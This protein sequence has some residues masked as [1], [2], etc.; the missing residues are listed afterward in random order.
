MPAAPAQGWEIEGRARRIPVGA[1]LHALIIGKTAASRERLAGVPLPL[2]QVAPAMGEGATVVI[3][4][5][6]GGE[7]GWLGAGGGV[8]ILK[9]AGGGHVFVTTYGITDDAAMPEVRLVNVDQLAAMQ[10]PAAAPQVA[11]APA[12]VEGREVRRELVLHIER[13][14]DRL[15]SAPGWAGNPGERL[16]VEGFA[17]R[18]LE[19]VAPGQIEYMA[20]GPGG[21]PT[22][23]VTDAKLCGTRGRGLPLTGFAVRLAPALRD[24]FDV[25]YEGYF[26]DSGVRG[27]Q[28]NGEPCLP[29]VGDD[30]LG[31]IRLRVVER[32]GA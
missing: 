15:F 4:S 21:R 10:V 20:F 9:A 17:V 28:R 32:P 30:P 3:V 7:G 24:R 16:R 23:W 14:G 22:P 26:F 5:N 11:P 6:S 27:P 31:A 12:P 2:T 19:T 8:V 29:A 18:P 1:G 25:V 13:Q